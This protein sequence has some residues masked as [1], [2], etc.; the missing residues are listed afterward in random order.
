MGTEEKLEKLKGLLGEMG[1]IL[2]AYSGG[3]D[4]TFLLKVAVDTL[5]NKAFAVTAKSPVYPA[6]EYLKA[7]EMAQVLGVKLFSLETFEMA[8]AEFTRNFPDRCYFCKTSLFAQLKEIAHLRGI[9]WVVDGTNFD[10]LEDF[11][12]GRKAAQDLDIRSPLCEVGLTKE[13]IRMLS[14]KLGLP[15]WDRPSSACLASRVPYGIPL[16]Q[17]VLERINEAEEFLLSLG[18]RQVRVRHHGELARIEVEPA[19]IKKVASASYE[20][21]AKLKALGYTYVA[22]DLE[23]YRPGSLNLMV[24]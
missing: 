2:L 8:R 6:R 24:R 18:L 19:D 22:L 20:V 12:P 1:S 3:V 23:G 21:V 11:R 7:R 5:G 15:T 17:E 4:S 14:K 13:E 9:K 16:T 10:D